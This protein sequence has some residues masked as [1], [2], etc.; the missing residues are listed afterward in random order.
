VVLL[1][2][3]PLIRQKDEGRDWGT[4]AKRTAEYAFVAAG[5]RQANELQRYLQQWQKVEG[6]EH[7]VARYHNRGMSR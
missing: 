7:E 5:E 2:G 6:L 3:T 4:Y 1:H